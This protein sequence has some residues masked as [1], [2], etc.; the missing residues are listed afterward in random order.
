MTQP[1]DSGRS[2]TPLASAPLLN[3][4]A[5]QRSMRGVSTIG[6]AADDSNAATALFQESRTMSTGCGAKSASC[7]DCF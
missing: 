2:P 3:C 1:I 6:L 5:S 4:R 7:S